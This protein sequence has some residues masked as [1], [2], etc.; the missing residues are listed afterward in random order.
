MAEDNGNDKKFE[1]SKVGD[2]PQYGIDEQLQRPA[3]NA[4]TDDMSEQ[5]SPNLKKIVRRKKNNVFKLRLGSRSPT[6]ITQKIIS[7]DGNKSPV[8]IRV[9]PYLADQRAFLGS[10]LNQLVI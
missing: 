1:C 2:E 8:K 3:H 9:L 7:L 6:D 4:A 5:E 10:Y